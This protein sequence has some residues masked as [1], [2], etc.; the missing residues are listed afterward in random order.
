MADNL[1]LGGWPLTKAMLP[2]PDCAV[3]DCT[4]ELLRHALRCA[5]RWCSLA[6]LSCSTS[7][8]QGSCRGRAPHAAFA[9]CG[10]PTGPLLTP[11]YTACRRPPPCPCPAR[12]WVRTPAYKAVLVFESWA[13]EPDDMRAAV[14]WALQQQAAGRPVFVHWWAGGAGRGGA[15][16]GGAGAAG[17]ARRGGRRRCARGGERSAPCCRSP[18]SPFRRMPAPAA[19]STHGHGRSAVTACAILCAMGKAAGPDEAL[20]QAVKVGW[21][22]GSPRR[23]G[24]GAGQCGGR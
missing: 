8:P 4:N 15:G 13:P 23:L 24:R 10:R 9:H 1:Y 20:A 7:M 22:G 11:A 6:W 19:R 21:A 5:V 17:M 18:V 12:R 3:L 16:R 2:S 14:A